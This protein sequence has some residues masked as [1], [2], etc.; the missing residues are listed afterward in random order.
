MEDDQEDGVRGWFESQHVEEHEYVVIK[1]NEAADSD[2]MRIDQ[3]PAAHYFELL[4]QHFRNQDR[5]NHLNK[6]YCKNLL[7]LFI[8][9]PSFSLSKNLYP[10]IYSSIKH[11]F[12][13]SPTLAT[14]THI[15]LA[16]QRIKRMSC[17]S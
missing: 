2:E 17:Y 6:F 16:F 8:T 12:N 10:L 5:G 4:C 7:S 3:P 15:K 9:P 1:C 13:L 14:I 11:S